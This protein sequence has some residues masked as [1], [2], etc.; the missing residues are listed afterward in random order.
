MSLQD[1]TYIA[2]HSSS[3]KADQT[4]ASEQPQQPEGQVSSIYS[5]INPRGSEMPEK[6]DAICMNPSLDCQSMSNEVNSVAAIS[7]T[8]IQ[9]SVDPSVG[10]SFDPGAI[11]AGALATIGHVSGLPPL[12]RSLSHRARM[13]RRRRRLR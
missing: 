2:H 4:I 5:N 12:L 10:N 13:R 1:G 6:T 8:Q 9:E 11:L 7:T 3:P